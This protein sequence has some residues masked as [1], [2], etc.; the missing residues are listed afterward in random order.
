MP[1]L[2]PSDT[3]SASGQTGFATATVDATDAGSIADASEADAQPRGCTSLKVRQLSR[4]VSQHFDRVL[5]GVDLKTTQFSLLSM[6]VKLGP[7]RP[8]ELAARLR[9]DASTLTRNLQPLIAHGWLCLGPGDDGRR[10]LVAAT[11]SGRTKQTEAKHH[12]KQAQTAFNR[13]LGSERV[14]RLHALIDEC[15]AALGESVDEDATA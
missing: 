1:S 10:R 12:W 6:V 11:D 5:A 2:F 14:A 7:L 3:S 9:M 13:K 15:L 8:G 4:R